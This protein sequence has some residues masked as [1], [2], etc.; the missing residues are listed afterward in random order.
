MNTTLSSVE[1]NFRSQLEQLEKIGTAVK[2]DTNF[3]DSKI[4]TLQSKVNEGT[5]FETEVAKFLYQGILPK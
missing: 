3:V 1:T 4:N 5:L 2:V